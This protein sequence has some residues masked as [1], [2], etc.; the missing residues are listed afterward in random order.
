M[1]AASVDLQGQGAVH[2]L[3]ALLHELPVLFLCIGNA[4]QRTA[5]A[6]AYPIT[7]H[8]LK[9]KASI[10]NGKLRCRHGKSRALIP[11]FVLMRGKP[12]PHIK[13]PDLRAMLRLG[14]WGLKT[15][16]PRYGAFFGAQSFPEGCF[17]C[18]YWRY[19]S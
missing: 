4:P 9:V 18:S 12:L 17:A 11:A 7:I 10:L 5:K 1:G 16:Q 3:G 2:T 19:R 6:D 8:G 14:V 15:L 13:I